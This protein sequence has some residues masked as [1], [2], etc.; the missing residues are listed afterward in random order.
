MIP[1]GNLLSLGID[2]NTSHLIFKFFRVYIALFCVK[3]PGPW[4]A[5]AL[6]LIKDSLTLEFVHYHVFGIL[7]F[8]LNNI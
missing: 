2:L 3:G 4:H 1:L 5:C 8:F 6:F 7:F